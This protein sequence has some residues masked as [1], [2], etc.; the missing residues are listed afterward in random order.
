MILTIFKRTR[1]NKNQWYNYAFLYNCNVS[2]HLTLNTA[3][4]LNEISILYSIAAL[5]LCVCVCVCVHFKLFS[6]FKDNLLM[7]VHFTL[8]T[9]LARQKEQTLLIFK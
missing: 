9:S 4:F 5:S 7:N 3:P 1:I 8:Y 6:K 2:M